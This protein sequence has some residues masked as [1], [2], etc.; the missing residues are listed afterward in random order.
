MSEIFY[1]L[2]Y[3]NLFPL[4]N[5]YFERGGPRLQTFEKKKRHQSNRDFIVSGQRANF[6]TPNVKLWRE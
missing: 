4:Q 1:D 2:T 3:K 6:F 5:N